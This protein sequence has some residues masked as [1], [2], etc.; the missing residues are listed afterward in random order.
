MNDLLTGQGNYANEYIHYTPA[1][2]KSKTPILKNNSLVSAAFSSGIE[3]AP[4]ELPYDTLTE[5]GLAERDDADEALLS[6]LQ[7]SRARLNDKLDNSEYE[8]NNNENVKKQIQ[9]NIQ[10]GDAATKIKS[11]VRGAQ[12][13]QEFKE[14]KE[15]KNKAAQRIQKVARLSGVTKAKIEKTPTSTPL[16]VVSEPIEKPTSSKKGKDDDDSD[17]TNLGDD[18]N[19]QKLF[20]ESI[21]SYGVLQSDLD[22]LILKGG[23]K[24]RIDQYPLLQQI[25]K[26]LYQRKIPEKFLNKTT[27]Q[28]TGGKHKIKSVSELTKTLDKIKKK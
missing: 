25:A 6:R 10:R 20:F 7:Q 18:P 24:T 5:Q 8:A 3:Q 19:N 12:A 22:K 27:D 4:K 9:E 1:Y 26:E 17:E 13:R 14:I 16:E 21:A 28:I 23:G 15:T 2:M 11:F